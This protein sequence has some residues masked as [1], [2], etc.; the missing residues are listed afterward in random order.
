MAE[1]TLTLLA[2]AVIL[3]L[4]VLLLELS[5]PL[6]KKQA[7]S[8]P[9]LYYNKELASE[10]RLPADFSTTEQ[11]IEMQARLQGLNHKT[12]MAHERIEGLEQEIVRAKTPASPEALLKIEKRIES[13]DNFKANTEVELQALKEILAGQIFERQRPV[14]SNYKRQKRLDEEYLHNV[15]FNRKR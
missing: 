4:A 6:R 9:V 3:F 8:V 14:E 15:I 11:V 12:R 10:E 13:L 2:L 5:K 1:I 7:Q